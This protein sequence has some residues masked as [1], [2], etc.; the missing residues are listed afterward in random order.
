MSKKTLYFSCEAGLTVGM[1]VSPVITGSPGETSH[2]CV[3]VATICLKS[4]L[5]QMYILCI[6]IL[7]LK[8]DADSTISLPE[9]VFYYIL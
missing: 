2:I 1:S 5:S 4:D 3:C 8:R 7:W 9:Y 6:T